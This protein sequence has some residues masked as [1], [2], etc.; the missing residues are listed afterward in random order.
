MSNIFLLVAFYLS[1]LG[2]IIAIVCYLPGVIKVFKYNDTRSISTLMYTLT[3]FG[4]TLWI[5][6]AIF[7]IIGYSQTQ[8]KSNDYIFSLASGL[9][10]LLS[11]AG[12]GTCS[13]LIL[14][15]KAKNVFK[16]KKH[17]MTE[18]EYYKKIVE[19][20]VIEKIAK[21]KQI[22]QESKQKIKAIKKEEE[23]KKTEEYPKF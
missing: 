18:D 21:Q 15:K 22:K 9:G 4:C 5:I 19:P 7:L 2:T 6:I 3:S 12:L 8:S 10:T 16:A 23:R 17:N 13:L 14:F 11:N 20:I 1:M